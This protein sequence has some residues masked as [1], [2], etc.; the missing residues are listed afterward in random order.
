MGGLRSHTLV[1]ATG[2]LVAPFADCSYPAPGKLDRS[3]A[4]GCGEG[5]GEAD[6][7]RAH[8]AIA[9]AM[10]TPIKKS[11]LIRSVR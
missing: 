1:V 2:M 9:G 11:T 6:D 5:G 10:L 3:L 8:K 7:A 4:A